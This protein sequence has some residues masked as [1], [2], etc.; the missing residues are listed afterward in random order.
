MFDQDGQHH[1][2]QLSQ[3]DPDSA[4]SLR[5]PSHQVIFRFS[6]VLSPSANEMEVHTDN[7]LSLIANLSRKWYVS[8]LD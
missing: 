1:S 6:N 7:Q 4:S 5:L 8:E 3:H 2:G